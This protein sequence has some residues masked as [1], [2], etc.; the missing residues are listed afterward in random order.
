MD[1]DEVWQR[2]VSRLTVIIRGGAFGGL[3][4]GPLT[5][6]SFKGISLSST[7]GAVFRDTRVRL[8]TLEQQQQHLIGWVDDFWQ[9]AFASLLGT[10]VFL[11]ARSGVC[12]ACGR[13]LGVTPKGHQARAGLCARCRR[14][15][16]ERSLTKSE[17]QERWRKNKAKQ[18]AKIQASTPTTGKGKRHGT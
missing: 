5:P 7:P 16:W 14:A 17:R 3:G 10:G 18:R 1:A 4:S 9:G 8:P 12:G 13:D 11:P 2:Y 15:E 6:Q